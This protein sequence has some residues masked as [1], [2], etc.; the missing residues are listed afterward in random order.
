MDDES[1]ERKR[2]K[3]SINFAED[4]KTAIYYANKYFGGNVSKLVRHLIREYDDNNKTTETTT[5]LQTIAFL[6]IG[7]CLIIMAVAYVVT[8]V[9]IILP[10]VLALCGIFVILYV[11]VKY[12]NTVSL[13]PPGVM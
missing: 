2:D 12:K 7:F 5:A 4:Y 10:V 1:G 9:Y 6:L 11:F 13:M 3:Q 8:I